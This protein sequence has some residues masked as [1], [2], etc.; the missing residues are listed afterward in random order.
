MRNVL[1]DTSFI[2]TCVRNKIDFFEQ[3]ELE[4]F[5]ILVPKQVIKEI[6]AIKNQI[7]SLETR[8]YYSCP[9]GCIEVNEE[10]AL[11]YHFICQECG[12][13]L[14][15]S[16]K[17]ARVKEFAS[18]ISRH[19]KQIAIAK[20]ELAE[21]EVKTL[22]NLEKLK[23]R[24]SLERKKKLAINKKIRDRAKK[25]PKHRKSEKLNKKKKKRR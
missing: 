14:V 21:I 4:G 15:L 25:K 19:E 24:K 22:K 7:T 11:H 12:Q 3:L 20:V 8:N 2:L 5:K 1:L 18:I 16:E 9:Y 17:T 6:E 23:K 13:L 10:T